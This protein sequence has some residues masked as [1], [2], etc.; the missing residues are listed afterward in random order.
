MM[1]RRYFI[2]VDDM[3]PK[4]YYRIT[5]NWLEL[6]VRFLYN[7]RGVRDLKD[8]MSRD[9]LTAFDA[10]GIGIASATYDIVGFPPVRLER[11]PSS[12]RSATRESRLETTGSIR[13]TALPERRKKRSGTGA[14]RVER[15]AQDES[16]H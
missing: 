14:W 2:T 1:Q 16:G 7:V 13:E 11:A 15:Y 8:A 10:A 3:A 12:G 9:I 4:V 5:D 6:T